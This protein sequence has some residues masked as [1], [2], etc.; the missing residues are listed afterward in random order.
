MISS[1]KTN[2][3][4]V[5]AYARSIW[6]LA[7]QGGFPTTIQNKVAPSA[8]MSIA[9]DFENSEAISELIKSSGDI[10]AT[11]TNKIKIKWKKENKVEKIREERLE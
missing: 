6:L 2:S 1:G 4:L 3:I 9:G 8:N 11:N 7:I 10:N 5:I